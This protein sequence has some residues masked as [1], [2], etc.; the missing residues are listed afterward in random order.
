MVKWIKLLFLL[1]AFNNAMAQ[2]HHFIFIESLNKQAFTVKVNDKFYESLNKFFVTIPKLENGTY[3]LLISAKSSMDNKFTV[4]V[5][6]EDVGFSLKQN[7][8]GDWVLF[9]INKFTTLLQD[10]KQLV[11]KE[12]PKEEPVIKPDTAAIKKPDTLKTIAEEVKAGDIKQGVKKIYQKKHTD[13]ID[14]VYIINEKTGTDTVSIYISNQPAKFAETPK[15]AE[16]QLPPAQKME[17]KNLDIAPAA[18]NNCTNVAT[19]TDIA[20][21]SSKLQS[22]GVLKTKLKIANAAFKEKCFTVNQLKRLSVLFINDNGKLNFFK[23]AQKFISDSNNF[24]Q[25]ENELNDDAIKD[26]FRAFI[27]QQ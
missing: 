6:K 10:G 17:S 1:M 13:G 18:N 2:T 19:E 4:V 25:L 12:E 8:E 21:F 15:Q 14:Q 11:K 20:N 9:D 22:S 24:A 5:D 23:L 27:N 7:A 26:E 3:T 16:P